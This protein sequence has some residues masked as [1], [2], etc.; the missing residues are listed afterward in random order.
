MFSECYLFQITVLA[1]LSRKISLK[2][3]NFVD[4]LKDTYFG[5]LQRYVT[6][7]KVNFFFFRVL[8]KIINVIT[9]AY[10]YGFR[11]K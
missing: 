9:S 6:R 8:F 7:T 5:T 1:K 4:C 10:Y 3:V 2:L 11:F